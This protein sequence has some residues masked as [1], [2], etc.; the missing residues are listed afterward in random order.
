MAVTLSFKNSEIKIPIRSNLDDQ[1]Q[2]LNDLVVRYYI[3]TEEQHLSLLLHLLENLLVTNEFAQTSYLSLTARA[4]LIKAT[5]LIFGSIFEAALR[6]I[7]E[8]RGLKFNKKEGK[9]GG[10]S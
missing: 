10:E 1:W 6:V 5:I 8:Q 2:N 3:T 7:G 4:G 9:K